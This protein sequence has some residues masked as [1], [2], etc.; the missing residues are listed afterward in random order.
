MKDSENRILLLEAIIDH[1]FEGYEKSRELVPITTNH[2]EFI[3]T[4]MSQLYN[5]AEVSPDIRNKV[6]LEVYKEK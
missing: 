2:L 6:E 4:I 3:D 5:Y 1:M